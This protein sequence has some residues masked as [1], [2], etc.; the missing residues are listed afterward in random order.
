LKAFNLIKSPDGTSQTAA[1]EYVD[2]TVTETALSGLN[3]LEIAEYKL[4]VQR[5]PEA[6]AK[7][8]LKPANANDDE[9]S[10]NSP[11]KM[12]VEQPPADPLASN[13]PTTILRLSN[14]TTKEDLTDDE[15]YLELKEDV[16][17]ECNRYGTVVSIVIPRS[18]DYGGIEADKEAV[19][20]I[21][22]KFTDVEGAKKAHK[23][24]HGRS[25]NGL[26]VNAVYYPEDLY[27]QKV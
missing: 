19:G 16:S 1:L 21:F 18:V 11:P 3:K 12:I 27:E 7:L 23:A 24:V 22:V 8:L 26:T 9:S 10:K 4:S 15:L 14:M 25:F 20:Q 5:I 2:T 6:T 13:P 17:E